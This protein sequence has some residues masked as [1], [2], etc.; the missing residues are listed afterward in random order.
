MKVLYIFHE[1]GEHNGA[2]K[3]AHNL[4]LKL[5]RSGIDLLILT[6]DK[7]E[8][9]NILKEEKFNVKSIKVVWYNRRA[10]NHLS[11]K[12]ER[13]PYEIRR[14][15]L[16]KIWMFKAGRIVK[17]FSPDIIHSNSSVFFLGYDLAKKYNIPHVWHIREYGKEDF[18][19][20]TLPTR[21]RLDEHISYN[22]CISKCLRA[23]RGLADDVRTTVIYNGIRDKKETSLFYPKDKF[24]L[25]VGSLNEGKGI[26]DILD[27]WKSYT[28]YSEDSFKLLIAG[29]KPNQIKQWKNYLGSQKIR[30]NIEFLG[31]RD[32]VFSLMSHARALIVGSYSEAFGRVTAE[33][34][35]CGC[36]V[37]GRNTAGTKE[38]FDN[39]LS[40]THN[41]IG[42]RFYTK[43]DLVQQIMKSIEMNEEEYLGFAKRAQRTVTT[44]YSSETNLQKVLAFYDEIIS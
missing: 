9:T 42:L 3:S 2:W 1:T 31:K 24:I 14:I 6:P 5:R 22:I 18:N 41:E 38:Q 39:G 36:L 30:D 11:Y 40:L 7:H 28:N 33:A 43:E 4:L 20:D 12:I 44:L 16:G 37:I 13:I 26:K 32:D 23:K 15:I 29:G 17:S 8:I 34:M 27:A 35:F 19:L 10:I 21:K 25:Y